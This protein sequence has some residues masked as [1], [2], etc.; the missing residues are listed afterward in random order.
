MA[1]VH[2]EHR[3]QKIELIEKGN[4][5]NIKILFADMDEVRDFTRIISKYPCDFNASTAERKNEI[6]AKSVL[7]LASLGY[8]KEIILEIREQD[9]NKL[10]EIIDSIRQFMTADDSLFKP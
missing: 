2:C 8:N 6:D 4:A 9:D 5:M 7:G 3:H 1:T 10:K